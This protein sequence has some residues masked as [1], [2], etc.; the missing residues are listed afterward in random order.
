LSA[1]KGEDNKD[2]F[3]T[4]VL[5]F[6]KRLKNGILVKYLESQEGLKLVF[7]FNPILFR[8]YGQQNL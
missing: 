4:K 5:K 7:E 2:S 3:C 1:Q 6:L 8:P